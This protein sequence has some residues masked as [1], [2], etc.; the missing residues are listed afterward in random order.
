MSDPAALQ[1]AE[2]LREAIITG[3]LAP[4]ER[5]REVALATQ[6]STSRVPVREALRELTAD[7]YVELRPNAGARV[8]QTTAADVQVLFDM[9]IVLEASLARSAAEV[10]A[11]GAP[12]PGAAAVGATVDG[13]A[14]D[15]AR[16]AALDTVREIL[17]AGDAAIAEGRNEQLAAL[18]LRFHN[19]LG[20][21][22][23]RAGFTGLLRQLTGRTQWLHS[24]APAHLHQ[25]G[26]AAW[27]EHWDILE[28]IESGEGDLA[29]GL[30]TRHLERSRDALMARH[31][32]APA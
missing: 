27:H 32:G 21:L 18:N 8:A 6:F 3:A 28:H 11:A 26:D 16:A 29:A 25:R 9:R 31:R 23:G 5:L 4:G 30:M 15:A 19:A 12:G 14:E 7:G 10:A 22:S 1:I 17:A 2:S 20:G 13:G 24:L